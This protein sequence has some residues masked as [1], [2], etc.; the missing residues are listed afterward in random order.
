MRRTHEARRGSA[1]AEPGAADGADGG[2]GEHPARRDAGRDPGPPGRHPLERPLWAL[3]VVLNV[4]VLAVVAAGLAG[5]DRVPDSLSNGPWDELV[6]T[7]LVVLLFWPAWA[8]ARTRMG[9]AWALGSSLPPAPD[10]AVGALADDISCRLGMRTR[11]GLRFLAN[12][13]TDRMPV[14]IAWGNGPLLVDRLLVDALWPAHPHMLAFVIAYGMAGI[15]LGQTRRADAV[16]L[17]LAASIPVFGGWLE[18]TQTASRDRLAAWIAPDGAAALT[19]LATGNT[20]WDEVSLD[21]LRAA[22]D[23]APGARWRRIAT[24][25]GTPD[26]LLERVAA[27]DRLGLLPGGA[28]AT[29]RAAR[30]PDAAPAAA[31]AER[32]TTSAPR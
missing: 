27:L 13:P 20:R 1:P 14:V 11:P 18:H 10:D 5:L 32:A 7:I 29:N 16:L 4:G 21:D 19:V 31:S 26:P 25:L 9:E 8:A 3:G 12:G 28:G 2:A 24:A 6:A 22:A 17:G 23:S 15:R 30:P